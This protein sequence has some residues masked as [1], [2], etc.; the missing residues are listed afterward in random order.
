MPL[1]YTC[2]N[3]VSEAHLTIYTMILSFNLS[4]FFRLRVPL[5]SVLFSRRAAEIIEPQRLCHWSTELS[6]EAFGFLGRIYE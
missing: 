4:S 3:F 6:R 1:N 2:L 5:F